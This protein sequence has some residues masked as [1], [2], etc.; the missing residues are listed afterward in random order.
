VVSSLSCGNLDISLTYNDAE[1]MGSVDVV[2]SKTNPTGNSVAYTLSTPSES[3][4]IATL[5]NIKVNVKNSAQPSA[6]QLTDSLSIQVT[7]C[8]VSSSTL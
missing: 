4:P 5:S 7:A 6:T 1:I 2:S 3:I 8:D